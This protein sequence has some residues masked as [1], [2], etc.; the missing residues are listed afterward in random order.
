MQAGIQAALDVASA[1][2]CLGVAAFFLRSERISPGE[3]LGAMGLAFLLLGAGYGVVTLDTQIAPHP[4]LTAVRFTARTLGAILLVVTYVARAAGSPSTAWRAAWGF[5]A[6]ALVVPVAYLA[7]P[8][9]L[10]DPDGL[11]FMP[12]VTGSFLLA[13]VVLIPRAGPISWRT[14][15]I[16]LAFAILGAER[17]AAGTVLLSGGVAW[18]EAF[19]AARLAALLLFLHAVWP[20]RGAWS[21]SPPSAPEPRE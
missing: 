4:A 20:G 14:R 13:A 21:Y 9:S 2:I 18:T 3:G 6:L 5:L 15:R 19:Y 7:F 8:G 12:L 1:L 16:P 17:I 11:R 10:P